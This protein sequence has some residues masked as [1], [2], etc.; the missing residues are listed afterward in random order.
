MAQI[1]ARNIPPVEKMQEVQ[2]LVRDP[3]ES[4]TDILRARELMKDYSPQ[5]LLAQ[6]QKIAAARAPRGQ[7]PVS[8]RPQMGVPASPPVAQPRRVFSEEG[9][10]I[11]TAQGGGRA[12]IPQQIENV[13]SKGRHGDTMLMHVNPQELRGLSS[14]LG[15]ATINPDTGLPEAFAWWLPL[16]GA[17]IGGIGAAATGHDWKKGLLFGGLAGLGAGFAAPALGLGGGA[18]SAALAPTAGMAGTSSLTPAITGQLASAT[19]PTG[20]GAV[21][22]GISSLP[23]GFQVT[24]MAAGLT[25]SAI[26]GIAASTPGFIGP[27]TALS[28]AAL[29]NMGGARNVPTTWF[30]REVA[31]PFLNKIRYGDQTGTSITPFQ[32]A[33]DPKTGQSTRYLTPDVLAGSKGTTAEGGAGTDI[34]GGIKKWWE[35]KGKLEKG[36]TIAGISALL[37]PLAQPKETDF[38]FQLP[39]KKVSE[40][41]LSGIETPK[42]RKTKELTQEEIE[43]RIFAGLPEEDRSYFEDA[44][45]AKKGGVIGRQVGGEVLAQ[46]GRREDNALMGGQV[47]HISAEEAD[48]LKRMGGA[49]TTNPVTGLPEYQIIRQPGPLLAGPG[50]KQPPSGFTYV[51]GIGVM[52]QP[53]L[54]PISEVGRTFL[55]KKP[56]T[57]QPFP[58]ITGGGGGGA[59]APSPFEFPDV[60]PFRSGLSSFNVED[61]LSRIL[62]SSTV[63]QQFTLPSTPTTFPGSPT[64]PAIPASVPSANLQQG[65]SAMES[66]FSRFQQAQGDPIVDLVSESVVPSQQG[67]LIRLAVGGIGGLGPGTGGVSGG[68]FGLTGGS[69]SG[70]AGSGPGVGGAGIGTGITG[71]EG[72]KTRSIPATV[73]RTGERTPARDAQVFSV[74]EGVPFTV[75]TADQAEAETLNAIGKTLGG[76][77][78]GLKSIVQTVTSPFTTFLAQ[79]MAKSTPQSVAESRAYLASPKG[80]AQVAAESAGVTQ[81]GDPSGGDPYHVPNPILGE[82]PMAAGTSPFIKQ[83]GLV[84]LAYGGEP[85]FAGHLQGRGDGMSDQIPFRVVPQT[86]QDIPNAPDMAVLSTDEYVFPAD[87]V[88][89]LGNGSSN[90]GAKILDDA[91]KR[92]R[93]ASIG[94][95]KQIK[96][97]DGTNVL[98]GALTT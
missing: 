35:P 10:R 8:T 98:T 46:H 75:T 80:K 89:M 25:Q 7:A 53:A 57:A 71:G 34:L 32:S 82:G 41:D 66:L 67:G 69:A 12:A 20:V 65:T 21:S 37:G 40:F 83:G 54:R 50:G 59:P 9:E 27:S 4:K 31:Q 91:V 43:E 51:P 36:L 17:A 97:I 93:Q 11:L 73:T 48:L 52:G 47:A 45:F 87:A 6:A 29:T 1:Y 2:R 49:G 86:P 26:P 42:A 72:P 85:V 77:T 56:H 60:D 96:E 74:I 92:V 78:Q 90:A 30:K 70:M 81:R 28:E 44:T 68:S 16:I 76:E 22:S 5:T 88:S 63:P 84:G 3:Q 79:M 39:I 62:G 55:K 18:A 13:A 38:G 24:P 64:L 15:P 95:P 19:L 61:R 94:T 33:F 14:L 23:F 58:F